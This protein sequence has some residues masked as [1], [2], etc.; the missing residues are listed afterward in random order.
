M[1]GLAPAIESHARAI[2]DTTA[3]SVDT[4]LTATEKLL[5]NEAE[6]AL[7][8]IIQESLSNVARHSGAD[9][10]WVRMF[11]AGRSVVATVEDNGRGFPV[12][13]V[14]SSGRGLGLFG[15]QE[16]GAYVGGTVEIDSKPGA[17]TRIK[18]TIP[19]VETARYA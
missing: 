12:G 7:Y 3:V 11:V 9:R 10:A 16:R 18:V 13:D 1:L 14:M 6:L 2:A 4:D 19:V 17:G 8:R 5:P 15:M